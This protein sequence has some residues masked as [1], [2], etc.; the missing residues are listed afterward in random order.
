MRNRKTKWDGRTDGRTDGHFEV[1]DSTEVENTE[2]TREN[3]FSLKV[4]K[5]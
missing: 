1:V 3:Y 5:H 4:K 2:T